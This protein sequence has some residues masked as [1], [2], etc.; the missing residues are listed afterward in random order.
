MEEEAKPEV[1]MAE[2]RDLAF[3][4]TDSGGFMVQANSLVEG[5]KMAADGK[6]SCETSCSVSSC[7]RALVCW[8]AGLTLVSITYRRSSCHSPATRPRIR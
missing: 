4:K 2:C 5:L 8:S 1:E 3:D 6:V 7:R